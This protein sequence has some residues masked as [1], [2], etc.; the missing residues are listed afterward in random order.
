MNCVVIKFESNRETN[1]RTLVRAHTH[2]LVLVSNLILLFFLFSY[3]SGGKQQQQQNRPT[4]DLALLILSSLPS[5]IRRENT[6]MLLNHYYTMMKENLN[7][8]NIDIEVTLG[9]TKEKLLDDYK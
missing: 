6:Q 8:I 4:N 3:L 7:K 5:K 1:K 9:Y 2:T